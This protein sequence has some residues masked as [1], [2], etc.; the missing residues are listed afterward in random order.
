VVND[1]LASRLVLILKEPRA[2]SHFT[3]YQR[4]YD[5]FNNQVGKV[6]IWLYGTD[7]QLRSKEQNIHL[8]RAG[9]PMQQG[10]TFGAEVG[11]SRTIADVKRIEVYIVETEDND[12][13]G[14][15]EI[16]I[17]H[18]C[19]SPP[20]RAPS[21]PPP[22]PSPPQ[23]PPSVASFHAFNGAVD[24]ARIAY[25]W[26]GRLGG[27]GGSG[28][29][30]STTGFTANECAQFCGSFESGSHVQFYT[31]SIANLPHTLFQ[32]TCYNASSWT[33]IDP[34]PTSG[35]IHG[36]STG[37]SNPLLSSVILPADDLE[38]GYIKPTDGRIVRV[39]VPP[40]TTAFDIT[41][42]IF[43]DTI[44]TP[45]NIFRVSP[46]RLNDCRPCLTLANDGTFQ[47]NLMFSE[48]GWWK[49]VTTQHAVRPRTLYTIRTVLHDRK[50]SIMIDF[51]SKT[52]AEPT[53]EAHAGL[54]LA[55][56]FPHHERQ[57]FF[58]SKSNNINGQPTGVLMDLDSIRIKGG[59]RSHQT[60]DFRFE[61]NDLLKN[62]IRYHVGFQA[63]SLSHASQLAS[64]ATASP[65]TA[66]AT[67]PGHAGG[68]VVFDRHSALVLQTSEVYLTQCFTTCV[69]MKR[70]MQID[71]LY[72][73]ILG[74]G[75]Q[76]VL[77]YEAYFDDISLKL[78]DQT[79]RAAPTSLAS[80]GTY[81]SH[82]CV[83]VAPVGG[84]AVLYANGT[85][86]GSAMREQQTAAPNVPFAVGASIDP[87]VF[88][89]T[90]NDRGFGGVIDDVKAW[91]RQLSDFEIHQVFAGD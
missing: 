65:S 1:A 35:F 52:N 55:G 60:M 57:V 19:E 32:C 68:G 70:T 30:T 23:S 51:G 40:T 13:S 75:E 38:S 10:D 20:S 43:T 44:L 33:V 66:I 62:S 24:G 11:L 64:Y 83:S 16:S 48:K 47:A 90:G 50:L 77:H 29:T 80:P 61:A 63:P 12:D 3:F 45:G 79:L 88:Q 58:A 46:W 59:I 87:T 54:S 84:E 22:P 6:S 15:A 28:S 39:P 37:A 26:P 31:D 78:G 53:A 76:L 56:E 27:G 4:L 7:G 86:V 82:M 25:A 69:W 71:T 34:N 17:L 21:S 74:F 91:A 8:S 89:Q 14:F 2:I 9:P 73:T 67:T 41:I 81:W 85:R 72:T 36:S 18:K 42:T 5:G 49:F